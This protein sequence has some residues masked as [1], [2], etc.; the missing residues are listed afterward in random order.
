MKKGNN[1]CRQKT[2]GAETLAGSSRVATEV[3]QGRLLSVDNSTS[4]PPRLDLLKVYVKALQPVK[5]AQNCKILE[6]NC[7]WY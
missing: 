6:R 4:K 2:A 5:F 1:I 3:S 7:P